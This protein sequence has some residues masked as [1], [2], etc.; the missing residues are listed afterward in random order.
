MLYLENVDQSFT[1]AINAGG[2]ELKAVADQ[3][4]GDRAGTLK[5]PFGHIWTL[6]TH[7]EDLSEDQIK[8]RMMAEFSE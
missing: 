4:Y 5:D 3:F 6:G 2:I 8:Q 7:K 1:Q